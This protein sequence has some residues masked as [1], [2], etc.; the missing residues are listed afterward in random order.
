[1]SAVLILRTNHKSE[2]LRKKKKKGILKFVECYDL[3][4]VAAFGIMVLLMVLLAII[5]LF[6]MHDRYI[7]KLIFLYRICLYFHLR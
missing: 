3:A 1:M 7:N 6:N 2:R 4:A 5:A